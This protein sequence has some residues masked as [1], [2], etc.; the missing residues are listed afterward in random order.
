MTAEISLPQRLYGTDQAVTAALSVTVGSLAFR[1]EGQ[2]L[3]TLR[4]SGFE[5]LRSVGLV[6]RDEF[7]GTYSLQ[8]HSCEIQADDRL[9]R[10][11]SEGVVTPEGQEPVL[12]WSLDMSL[13]EREVSVSVRLQARS[14][15]T[16]CRAGLMV[17]HPLKGVVAM[18]V[19]VTHS[20]GQ[21]QQGAFPDLIAPIQPFFD[22]RRL[23]H[24]PMP[25][26][27]LE[28]SFSGDVFEMEDQ[29]NWS[30][31]SFKT[32]NR[33]LA[34]P[35]PYILDAGETVEQCISVKLIGQAQVHS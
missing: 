15:F 26:L 18:P 10:Q 11:V 34:W 6:I 8:Q 29:R 23:V 30:D 24:S 19:H 7:W 3:R 1:V 13:A 9:W 4:V 25:G 32:Y 20:D 16:T 28:W 12:D 22:I 5:V 17:L 2:Q 21:T 14:A 33:P 27:S 35:C 31:A